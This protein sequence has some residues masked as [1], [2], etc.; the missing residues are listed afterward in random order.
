MVFITSIAS[1]HLPCS[2]HTSKTE[3][4]HVSSGTMPTSSISSMSAK[5]CLNQSINPVQHQ[6]HLNLNF[7]CVQI[8]AKLTTSNQ[9]MTYIPYWKVIIYCPWR[10]WATWLGSVCLAH[11]IGQLSLASRDPINATNRLF[12]GSLVRMISPG[13]HNLLRFLVNNA[14]FETFGISKNKK[15]V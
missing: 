8:W 7:N 1:H 6:C 13:N 3:A 4:K 15:R 14:I 11:R 9:R 10:H 12:L 2:P 5:A